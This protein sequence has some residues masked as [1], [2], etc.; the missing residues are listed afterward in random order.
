MRVFVTGNRGYIGAHVVD[1]LKQHGHEVTGCDIGL[2][3]GC[4]WEPLVVPDCEFQQ[5]VR[6]LTEYDLE[7]H[8]AVIH[9]AAISNDPM[10]E[11]DPELTLAVNGEASIQLAQRAKAAGVPRFLFASSCS[12]Y[13]KGERLDLDERAALN[14][15]SAYAQSKILAEAGIARLADDTFSPIFLRSATAYGDSSMLRIDLVA[16]NLL[17][18]ALV[19]GEVRVMSDGTPWRPLIHCRDIARAFLAFAEAPCEAIHNRHVNVGANTENYQVSDVAEIV[20][21]LVPNAAI[22]FTGEIGH[23]PR[24]YRVSFDLLGQVLPDFHLSYTLREG[25]VE[26]HRQYVKHGFGR[27]DFEGDQF[28]RLRRLRVVKPLLSGLQ[29]VEAVGTAGLQGSVAE[30]RHHESVR[31]RPSSSS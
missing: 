12:I 3:A 4:D 25:M 28:V 10:A 14:P 2:F 9:L 20:K 16:N 8:D 7:N 5:D 31:S 23:D 26:L 29:A 1:L 21:T 19:Y 6:A 15:I 24:D 22:V 27:S 17:A 30:A 18:S 11:V 13:G